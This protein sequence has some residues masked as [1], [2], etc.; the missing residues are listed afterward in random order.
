[1]EATRTS[2]VLPPAWTEVLDRVQEA[3]TT[4]I[5]A[6]AERERAT[7]AARPCPGF[8]GH[9]RLERVNEILRGLQGVMEQ[10]A[11]QAAE[12][13]TVLGAAEDAL[14]EWL[15]GAAAAGTGDASD[16]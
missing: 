8:D 15:A 4:A 13:D 12:A 1:M 7:P 10:A 5:A 9:P 14:R 3:L 16:G 11:R 2:P 6:A